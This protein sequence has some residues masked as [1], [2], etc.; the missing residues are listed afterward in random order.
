MCLKT[1]SYDAVIIG[2]GI[3]GLITAGLLTKRGLRI[4][5]F[6]KE[7]EPGGYCRSFSNSGYTF[8]ACIDSI[9]ALQKGGFLYKVM[10]ELAILNKIQLVDINPMRRNIFPDFSIDITSNI[11]QHKEQLKNLF[12][13]KSN[14]VAELFCLMDDIFESLVL[15]VSGEA[16]S[17][18]VYFWANRSFKEL[19]DSFIANPLLKA[20]LSSYCVFLGLPATKVSAIAAVSVLMHY[21]KGGAFRVRGGIQK[22]INAITE[23]IVHNG[24]KV[25]LGEKVDKVNIIKGK[26][27]GVTTV[28]GRTIEADHI[29]S[30]IDANTLISSLI[31]CDVLP[32][33]KIQAIK[34]LNVSSSLIV[35]Y[36]GVDYDMSKLN[37]V[38]SIGYFSCNDLDAMLNIDNKLSFGISIPSLVDNT[39][40]PQGHGTVLIHWPCC[41]NEQG[42]RDKNTIADILIEHLEQIIPRI[43]KHIVFRSVA[44]SKTFFRYTGN[45]NGAAYGW[46]QSPGFLANA[47]LLSSLAK[48]LYQVGH[49]AGYGGGIMPSA[50]SAVRVANNIT[51]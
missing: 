13:S 47:A 26:A 7:E 41:Q 34:E 18:N 36:L 6:E 42:S 16:N 11:K 46:E 35:V 3:G 22:L 39:L 23:M 40:A 31:G 51:Q 28:K 29:V 21:L 15:S 50:I 2:A 4:A 19:L 30:D 43:T 24:G 25:I 37:L 14:G 17:A 48:N 5:V 8:D 20:Q 27:Y 33:K 49:W 38:P 9:G 10:E 44:D 12:P 45:T 32:F 1:E